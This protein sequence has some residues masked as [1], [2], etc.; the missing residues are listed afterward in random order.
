MDLFALALYLAC[1]E[2]LRRDVTGLYYQT[3]K[4]LHW[5]YCYIENDDA[6][7]IKRNEDFMSTA[8]YSSRTKPKA[9]GSTCISSAFCH[10]RYLGFY[11]F[12]GSVFWGLFLLTHLLLPPSYK[13]VCVCLR[14]RKRERE[15]DRE[16]TAH[17]RVFS[18][19]CSHER[20]VK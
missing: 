10:E 7:G 15:R 17:P 13:A 2:S 14:V 20:S 1:P 18:Q 3:T 12:E 5:I 6:S 11:V 16:S 8:L 4:L 19:S 9:L